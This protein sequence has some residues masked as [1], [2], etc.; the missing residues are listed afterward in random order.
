MLNDRRIDIND[1]PSV[2]GKMPG[3]KP[4]NYTSTAAFTCSSVMALASKSSPT[5]GFELGMPPVTPDRRAAAQHSVQIRHEFFNE[6]GTQLNKR[7]AN[8]ST[9]ADIEPEAFQYPLRHRKRIC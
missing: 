8:S 5:V 7:G 2:I 4:E 6:I 3:S 9:L 1:Y